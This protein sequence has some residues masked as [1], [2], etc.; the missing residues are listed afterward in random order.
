M[1]VKLNCQNEHSIK[2]GIVDGINHKLFYTSKIPLY[3]EGG[4]L[5]VSTH[6]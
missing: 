1:N 4:D 2:L 5:S 3:S 6:Q